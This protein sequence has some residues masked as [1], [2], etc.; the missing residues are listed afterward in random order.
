[1]HILEFLKKD[2][3]LPQTSLF[4]IITLSGMANSA[5][6]IV[7]NAAVDQIVREG[8]PGQLFALFILLL[9][10]FLYTQYYV[11]HEVVKAVEGGLQQMRCRLI[12]KIQQVSAPVTENS[13]SLG[14]ITTLTQ[15]AATIAQGSLRLT[16]ALQ[17]LLMI[18]FSAMYLLVISPLSFVLLILFLAALI[19]VF[20]LN[21]HQA[22]RKLKH[23]HSTQITITG[24]LVDLLAGFKELKL[25]ANARE[26]FLHE[27]RDLI[28]E[29]ARLKTQGNR[30][31]NTDFI[32]SNLARYL[33]LLLAVFVVPVLTWETTGTA[34]HVVAAVLFIVAPVTLLT[35]GLPNLVRTESSIGNLYALEAELDAAE[36]DIVRTQQQTPTTFQQITLHQVG[37]RYATE[38]ALPLSF[39][40]Y[41][42]TI[43]P[44]EAVF[45]TGANGSGKST[46]LKLLSGLYVPTV[47]ELTWDAQRVTADNLSVYRSL[48]AGVF[49]D[50]VFF[51]QLYGI[52]ASDADV[53]AIADWLVNMQLQDKVSYQPDRH[54][55][56]ITQLSIGEQ[57]RLHL[58][59]GVLK[60]RP[61]LLLDE[62][63]VDQDPEFLRH[64]YQQ[65]LPQLKAL[66]H[67]IVLVTH[68]EDYFGLADQVLVLQDGKLLSKKFDIT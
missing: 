40:P 64:F 56:S 15:D 63:T 60:Q 33:L 29:S 4:A 1:V 39:G 61:V 57:K 19:P 34:H 41:D 46:L 32:F 48:F 23:S 62:L 28:H 53:A 10:L 27:V 55:F 30:Q 2:L 58:I 68:D 5:L 12:D 49:S 13:L 35:N 47:G 65:V 51:D 11:L 8:E 42:M 36:Q 18:V 38:Q 21:S 22:T 45:I 24:K 3:A 67:A 16:M 26:D 59:V 54:C 52:S 20:S 37:F 14:Y 44:G 7:V 66:G 43:C 17:S 50:N 31:I 9:A 6:L 25:N